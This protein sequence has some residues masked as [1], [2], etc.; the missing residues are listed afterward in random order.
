MSAKK[1]ARIS[2]IIVYA[3]LVFFAIVILIPLIYVFSGSLKSNMELMAHPEKFFP[4]AVTFSNY[5]EV[6][7]SE[8]MNV[9]RMLINSI[10]YAAI[11]VVASVLFSLMAAYAFARGE[12]PGKKLLYAVFIGIMFINLGGI[13]TY[14]LFE[15]LGLFHVNISLNGLLIVKIF[16]IH[17]TFIILIRAYIQSIPK[18]LDEAAKIDGCGTIRILFTIIA[19]LL[20]P[21]IATVVILAFQNS[22]NEYIMPQIFTGSLP[23]QRTLTVGLVA[24]KNSGQGAASNTLLLA[25]ACISILPVLAVYCFFNKY[26]VSGLS[27][28]AVKG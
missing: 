15:L 18:E 1:S 9:G 28:G 5:L 25:G 14:P 21:I 3:L 24:L 13:T 20:K 2:N 8:T 11:N 16:S 22:W 7:T 26:F 19:P 12:F 6:F 23:D 4:E 17:A 27:A 10:Y